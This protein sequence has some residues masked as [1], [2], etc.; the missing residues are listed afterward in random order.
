M[1]NTNPTKKPRWTQMHRKEKQ[2]L[3]HVWITYQQ[4]YPMNKTM[5]NTHRFINKWLYNMVCLT[6]N[7]CLSVWYQDLDVNLFLSLSFLWLARALVGVLMS[8]ILSPNK[9]VFA[10]WQRVVSVVICYI[11]DHYC[12]RFE[13][14][15]V[16]VVQV[17]YIVDH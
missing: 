11:V 8:F 7:V 17:C 15:W 3:V 16:L 6:Y 9:L 10:I 1:N 4:L 13:R 12:L 5:L 14:G 2:F